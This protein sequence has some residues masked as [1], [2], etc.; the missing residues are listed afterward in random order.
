MQL[1]TQN[2]KLSFIF[3]YYNLDVDTKLE[4][5]PIADTDLI[6]VEYFDSKSEPLFEKKSLEFREGACPGCPN[7]VKKILI[8]H[9]ACKEVSIHS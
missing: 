1:R 7:K 9:C 3:P 4:H 5:L 6:L 8:Y 2:V